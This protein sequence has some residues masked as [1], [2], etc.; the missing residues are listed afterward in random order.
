MNWNPAWNA[1]VSA[2]L[3]GKGSASEPCVYIAGEESHRRT[4]ESLRLLAL[5]RAKRTR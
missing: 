2:G 3:G 1:F 4:P 5:I